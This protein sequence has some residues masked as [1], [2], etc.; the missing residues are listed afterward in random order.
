[1]QSAR[2]FVDTVSLLQEIGDIFTGKGLEFNGVFN[3]PMV[4]S[5]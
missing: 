5:G 1:M 4:P 3:G 2:F